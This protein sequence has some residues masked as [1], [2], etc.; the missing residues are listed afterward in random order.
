MWLAK[1]LPLFKVAML[2]IERLDGSEG[3]VIRLI[4]RL[5]SD[6][7][8][9]LEA[10]LSRCKGNLALDL[11]EVNLV[12]ADSVRFLVSAEKKGIKVLSASPFVREWMSKIREA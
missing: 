2:R 7:L 12:D 4:G 1:Q 11:E 3:N 6:Q 9:H 5:E 8:G 10:Q